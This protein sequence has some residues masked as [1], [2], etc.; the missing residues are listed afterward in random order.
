MACTHIKIGECLACENLQIKQQIEKLNKYINQHPSRA[1]KIE[2][3]MGVT[4]WM[5]LNKLIEALK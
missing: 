2:D 5:L 3:A 4:G 1:V